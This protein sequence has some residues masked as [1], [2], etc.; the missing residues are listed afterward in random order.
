MEAQQTEP[1]SQGARPGEKKL[2]GR[3]AVA[4]Q[5]VA[6]AFT[7]YAA[8]ALGPTFVGQLIAGVVA[9]L[10]GAFLAAPTQHRTHRFVAVALFVALLE[11]LGLRGSGAR[12]KASSRPAATGTGAQSASWA[13][14]SWAAVGIAATV[15]FAG[16][17]GI[18]TARDGWEP[19]PGHHVVTVTVPKIQGQTVRAARKQLVGRGFRVTVKRR[20]SERVAERHVV[21]TVPPGRSRAE[22]GSLVTVTV[23]AGRKLV[24]IPSVTGMS[25]EEAV[26]AL[27]DLDITATVEH[28]RSDRIAKGEA[29]QTEPP[30][31]TRT[32]RGSTV[33]LVISDWYRVIVPEI[34]GLTQ[35][36]ARTI[37]GERSLTVSTALEETLDTPS[38]VVVGIDPPA[39]ERV[40]GGSTVVVTV[41]HHVGRD[42]GDFE[43]QEEAQ[44]YFEALGGPA[45]D[46]DELDGDGDGVACE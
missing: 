5:C 19:I 31:Y 12:R 17:S 22:K 8:Q 27:D 28:E 7:T 34:T 4:L 10:L 16:G 18:T 6:S 13:P 2:G 36:E 21:S 11:A 37:L 38:G 9:T 41:A 46:P 24:E 15:G 29:I 1:A 25:W 20:R 26:S 42:C 43:S 32:E 33:T 45:E 3:E 23:S 30:A 35:G 39:G 40:G 14:T 44:R